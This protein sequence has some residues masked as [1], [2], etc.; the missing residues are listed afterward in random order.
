MTEKPVLTPE[1]I[2]REA[3]RLLQQ[4]LRYG[5]DMWEPYV[6]RTWRA[7]CRVWLRR[8]CTPWKPPL[9]QR[10]PYTFDP[11]WTPGPDT[12]RLRK[13]PREVR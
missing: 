8:V 12:I 6:P 9:L 2:T 3:L 10:K 7:R 5:V 1:I 13:P 4:S 11:A